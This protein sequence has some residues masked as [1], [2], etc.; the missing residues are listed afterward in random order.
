MK[1]NIPM[2]AEARGFFGKGK[3]KKKKGG[4]NKRSQMLRMVMPLMSHTTGERLANA[5]DGNNVTLMRD[6][7]EKIGNEIAKQLEHRAKKGGI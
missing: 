4:G 3:G 6:V 2:K 5:I 1:I 7:W